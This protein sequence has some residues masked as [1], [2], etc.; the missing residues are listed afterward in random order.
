ME[1]NQGKPEAMKRTPVYP[2]IILL[3]ALLTAFSQ[4][5]SVAKADCSHCTLE[6]SVLPECCTAGNPESESE[7]P[8]GSCQHAGL[9]S[10]DDSLPAVAAAA[11]FMEAAAIVR[12]H[13]FFRSE[14]RKPRQ[15]SFAGSAPLPDLLPPLFLL[16]CSFLI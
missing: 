15:I 5:V 7:E 8:D 2:F 13:S 1:K 16:N 10:G 6:Y 9:C 11:V 3:L 12:Q 4:A 14:I